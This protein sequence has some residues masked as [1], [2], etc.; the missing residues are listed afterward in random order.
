LATFA[1][2]LTR[3]EGLIRWSEPGKK[4]VNLVRAFDPWP[5]AY[6]LRDG[7]ELKLW[8]A[9]A[10]DDASAASGIPRAPG[11]V[12]RAAEAEGEPLVIAAGEG[13]VA[14]HEVQPASGQRMSAA[15]YLRGHPL[16][17]GTVLGGPHH[18]PSSLPRR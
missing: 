4:I 9:T 15:A 13:N 14:I 7:E 11:T 12:L 5:V 2:K 18:A 10:L 3:A 8:R 1:P 17:P 6:T 16:V